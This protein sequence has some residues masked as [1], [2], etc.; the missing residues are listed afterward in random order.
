MV[1]VAKETAV[2]ETTASASDPWRE[3][4]QALARTH[5]MVQTAPGKPLLFLDRPHLQ[6]HLLQQAYQKFAAAA[7]TELTVSYAGEW[8]LDNFY[9]IQ[10][11]LRQIHD[12]IPAKYYH[13]LPKL[14]ETPLENYPRVYAIARTI[15]YLTRGHLA[16]D[17]L[18]DFLI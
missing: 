9:V 2:Q 13:E 12:D 5:Q 4:A 11:A 6:G 7:Q 15:I 10:Q 14:A 8:M 17:P 18:R 1:V 16:I 3:S